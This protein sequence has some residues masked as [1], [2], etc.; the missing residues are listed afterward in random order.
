MSNASGTKSVVV[1]MELRSGD[2]ITTDRG[3]TVDLWL[4]LN[5]DALRVEPESSLR[6][7]TLEINNPAERTFTTSMSLGKGGVVGNVAGKI[8]LASKYEVKTASGVAGIR[9]TIYSLRTD[10][11][12]VVARGSVTFNFVINGQNRTVRVEAGQQFKPG[13]AAPTPA[14]PQ[15]LAV[16]TEAAASLGQSTGIVSTDGGTVTVADNPLNVSVSQ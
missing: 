11:T 8:S 13:D 3:S 9:G 5:G 10:G 14:P 1:G 6:L 12:L 2:T 15:L 16:V 4:G 7:D